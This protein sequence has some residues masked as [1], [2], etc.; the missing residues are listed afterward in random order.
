MTAQ[1]AHPGWCAHDVTAEFDG[2]EHVSRRH[3]WRPVYEHEAAIVDEL[4]QVV[5]PDGGA[6][7]PAAVVR[8]DNPGNPG[9]VAMTADDLTAFVDHLA[10]LRTALTSEHGPSHP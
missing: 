2:T 5:Y 9:E 7:I 4:R 3:R 10:R 6:E 1:D 8:I